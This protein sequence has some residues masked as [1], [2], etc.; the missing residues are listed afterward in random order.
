[1]GGVRKRS[2]T[3]GGHR[4]S[5]SVEDEF[6]AELERLATAADRSLASLVAEIDRDRA[7]DA[8]LSSAIRLHILRALKREIDVS[9]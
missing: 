9:D 3:I 7:P 8:N 6:F 5:F 4:T 2:V 1:M